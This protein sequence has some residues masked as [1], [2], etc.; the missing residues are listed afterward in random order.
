MTKK[1]KTY[2]KQTKQNKTL[3]FPNSAL[4]LV[5]GKKDNN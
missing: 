1:K 4:P 3:Y 2:K 5:M